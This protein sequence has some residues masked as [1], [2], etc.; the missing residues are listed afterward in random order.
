[1]LGSKCEMYAME[2]SDSTLKVLIKH[3]KEKAHEGRHNPEY[4]QEQMR[5]ANVFEE[6]L[7][8]RR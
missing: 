8:S 3:T 1:M 5:M 7:K 4:Y 2:L 6:E